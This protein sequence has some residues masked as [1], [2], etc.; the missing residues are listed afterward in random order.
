MVIVNG[1]GALPCKGLCLEDGDRLCKYVC[2]A[3]PDVWRQAQIVSSKKQQIS[4]RFLSDGKIE[5]KRTRT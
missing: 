4:I 5:N 2:E 3:L 1:R